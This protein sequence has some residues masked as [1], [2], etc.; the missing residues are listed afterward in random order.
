MGVEC[1]ESS[2][3]STVLGESGPEGSE[4]EGGGGS[5]DGVAVAVVV[6]DDGLVALAVSATSPF[7]I[8]VMLL[9]LDVLEE[10]REWC[11]VPLALEGGDEDTT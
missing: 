5:V 2:S 10:R 11:M 3:S 4:P 7:V 1:R 8:T 6:G 9:L